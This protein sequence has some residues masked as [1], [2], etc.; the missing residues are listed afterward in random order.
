MP[1]IRELLQA[2][3]ATIPLRAYAYLTTALRDRSIGADVL[4]CLIP[5]L[6]AGVEMQ[7]DGAILDEKALSSFLKSLGLH[8]PELVLEHLE[9]RLEQLGLLERRSGGDYQVKHPNS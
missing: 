7:P 3:T 8:I 4:D 6:R 2:K 9:G 1:S 5:F